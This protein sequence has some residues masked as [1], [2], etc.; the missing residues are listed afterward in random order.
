[1]YLAR[2]FLNP[3]S[4]D[5]GRDLR[6]LTGLHRTVLRA[7]PDGLGATPRAT[8][9][10][11]FRV[12][13][14]RGGALLVIQSRERP[15]LGKLPPRYFLDP[16]DDRLFD[17]GWSTNPRVEAI[18][19][20]RY[21]DG[22][23][24]AFRLVANV[25][26]KIDT[27]TGPD[28]KRRNGKRVPL[29]TDDERMAWLARHARDAGF[30]VVDARVNAGAAASGSRGEADPVTFA[31]TRFDGVLEVR[32]ADRFREALATGIGPGKAYGFGLLSIAP[33]R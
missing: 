19:V 10:V 14:G 29:R 32:D 5:V 27:K 16:D 3:V 21:V 30:A 4:R 11:L 28:G 1:M 18:D 15:D 13:V 22:T 9:G 7:F 6:D 8:A 2:G 25:T 33:L 31:G 20:A 26:K 23:R 17:L 12:D 24:L